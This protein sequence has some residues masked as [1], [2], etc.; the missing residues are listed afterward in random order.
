MWLYGEGGQTC[1]RS[2]VWGMTDDLRGLRATE[3]TEIRGRM[4]SALILTKIRAL[5]RGLRESS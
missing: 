5:H 2:R 1:E 4:D 3:E